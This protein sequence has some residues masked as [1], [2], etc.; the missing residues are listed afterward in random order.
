MTR[1]DT[2]DSARLTLDGLVEQ[3]AKAYGD[4]LVGIVLYGS[5]A[6]DAAIRGHSDLNVLVV[7]DGISVA[8]LRQ[9]GPTARAWQEAGNP[10]PLVLTRNEWER[11]ADIFPM[12]YA[13]ILERHRVLFGT[14]PLDGIRVSVADLRL[15]TEQEAMGKLLRL[16]RAVMA[17]GADHRRGLELLRSSISSLL[18]IFRAVVR[19][20][21]DRPDRDNA[22]V[23]RATAARAGFDAGPFQRV[24]RL[25]GGDTMG[26]REIEPTLAGYVEGMEALVRYLDAFGSGATDA[27]SPS[28]GHT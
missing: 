27:S 3:V 11:S 4:G 21:G 16:R 28:R 8:T 12:E 20:H 18:V 10:P 19:L 15:Q 14:L 24:L 13:D 1:N 25:V 9:L 26:E 22:E 5:A 2:H 17:A 6:N 7:V 23:V